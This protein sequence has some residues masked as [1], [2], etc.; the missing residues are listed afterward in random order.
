MGSYFHEIVQ[1]L[2]FYHIPCTMSGQLLLEEFLE[3]RREVDFDSTCLNI[4]W[5]DNSLFPPLPK[6]S[7]KYE[8]QLLISPQAKPT[9]LTIRFSKK[10]DNICNFILYHGVTAPLT[11]NNMPW[12]YATFGSKN[13]NY[14][15]VFCSNLLERD[16]YPF[17]GHANIIFIS[18]G[19]DSYKVYRL[20]VYGDFLEYTDGSQYFG[21]RSDFHRRPLKWGF[22]SLAKPILARHPIESFK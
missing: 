17:S 12:N 9:L 19:E 4:R 14:H 7:A 8:V 20:D 5:G 2:L 10:Y 16:S 22:S 11:R 13:T 21:K 3:M 18:M 1:I 15:V 6:T